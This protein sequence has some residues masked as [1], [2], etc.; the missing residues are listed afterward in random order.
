[1]WAYMIHPEIDG[2]TLVSTAAV[3]VWEGLGWQRADAPEG[4]DLDDPHA[5]TVLAESANVPAGHQPPLKRREPEPEPEPKSK[6]R[7]AK[8]TASQEEEAE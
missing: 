2:E 3:E 6:R 5:P 1:M 7:P 4:L 8:T